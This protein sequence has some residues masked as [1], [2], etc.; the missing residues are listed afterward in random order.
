MRSEGTP[1]LRSSSTSRAA[2]SWLPSRCVEEGGGA[3]GP[4]SRRA[5]PCCKAR[6]HQEAEADLYYLPSLAHLHID[7]DGGRE[8]GHQQLAGGIKR[9]KVLGGGHLCIANNCRK[10]LSGIQC[11]EA[12]RQH[13]HH[14]TDGSRVCTWTAKHGPSAASRYHNGSAEQASNASQ[15]GPPEMMPAIFRVGPTTA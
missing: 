7:K 5:W 1:L 9:A 14:A 8:V 6:S 12:Q 10:R 3:S 11:W 15:D 13:A 4:L 2:S